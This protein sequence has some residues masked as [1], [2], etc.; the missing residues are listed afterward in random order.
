LGQ[1]WEAVGTKLADRW[2]A[3]S[4]PALVFWLGGLLAW[5]HSRGGLQALKP[6]T[7]W[8]G[9]QPISTQVAIMLAVLLGVVASGA[10]VQRLTVPMLRLVE[11]YWPTLLN[12]VRQSLVRRVERRADTFEARFQQ[13]AGA[14]S[15]NGATP[16]QRADFVVVDQELRRLPGN[17]QFQPTR[18]G[19]IIR[20][21]E[22]RPVD[23]Y[24]LD[25]VALWPHLWLL[26]PEN[27]QKELAT[28]RLSLDSAVAA[29]I[30]GTL[31]VCFAPWTLLAIPAGVGFVVIIYFGWLPSRA[32]VYADL[33]E[34]AFDLYRGALYAQLR[35]PLPTDSQDE[36]VQGRKMTAYLLRGPS[37][38]TP[39]FTAP[40]NPSS[41]ASR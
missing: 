19:N 37:G 40:T 11:G 34:A 7:D 16:R 25:A 15:S 6:P 18:I 13:L 14:V 1:F 12:P 39:A 33:V 38:T 9:N 28:A 24:G 2:A 35:W 22:S 10:I 17:R 20:A 5:A 8:L 27:T 31:F 41:N 23:K 29:C 3:I 32:K 4:G 30:W 21:S 36:R 26:L